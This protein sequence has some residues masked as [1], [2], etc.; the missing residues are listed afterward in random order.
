MVRSRDL[1]N[2][3][4][5]GGSKVERFPILSQTEFHSR[6]SLGPEMETAIS[7]KEICMS[8]KL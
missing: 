5:K 6:I 8:S 4:A 1:G 3:G 7:E 2:E